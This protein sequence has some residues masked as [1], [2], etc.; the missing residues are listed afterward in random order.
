MGYFCYDLL[1]YMFHKID[2][3]NNSNIKKSAFNR[4]N[5]SMDFHENGLENDDKS[6]EEVIKL[7]MD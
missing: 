6:S 5:N 4:K 3:T 1:K 2:E 7:R